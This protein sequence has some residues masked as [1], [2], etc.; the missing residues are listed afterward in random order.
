MNALLP[1]S[2]RPRLTGFTLIEL[3]VVISIISILAGLLLPSL[4][5][6]KAKASRIKCVSN[7]KQVGLSFR[8]WADGNEGR[9]P[10]QVPISQGGTRTI[11]EAWAHYN[12]LA[13]ELVT[14][15]VL[16]CPTDRSKT[17]A[18]GFTTNPNGFATLKNEA[19]SYTVG[20]E[21]RDDSPMMHV[22]S[23]RNVMGFESSTCPPAGITDAVV[24]RLDPNLDNPRWDS[25]LHGWAGNMVLVD[26]SAHQYSKS[27]LQGHCQTPSLGDTN[28]SN[29]TLKPR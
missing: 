13:I 24:T 25:T 11:S 3:L 27:G 6:A 15:R 4:S 2:Q 26:G 22:A 29:C 14:P 9:L 1:R 18:Q 10:W 19:L 28:L 17:E 21:A 5:R 23:D 7:L 16:I 12:L 20:T 8:M